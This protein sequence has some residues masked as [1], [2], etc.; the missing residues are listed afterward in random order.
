MDGCG[1]LLLTT[2]DKEAS[3]TPTR[4]TGLFLKTSS[5]RFK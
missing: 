5:D 2:P 3:G 1:I 4:F